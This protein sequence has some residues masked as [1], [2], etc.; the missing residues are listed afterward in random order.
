MCGLNGLALPDGWGRALN[1]FKGSYIQFMPWKEIMQGSR[2]AC[3]W[4][5][6]ALAACLFLKNSNQMAENFRPGWKSLLVIAAGAYAALQL[7]RMN[8]FLYFNF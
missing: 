6:L 4:V 5:P 8:E 7:F 3:I 2:D 1:F